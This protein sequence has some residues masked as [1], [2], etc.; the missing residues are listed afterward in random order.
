[1]LSSLATSAKFRECWA[2]ASTR[3]AE[4]W[5]NRSPKSTAAEPPQ[6]GTTAF[7]A[8][9]HGSAMVAIVV[10]AAIFF[11]IMPVRCTAIVRNFRPSSMRMVA[12]APGKRVRQQYQRQE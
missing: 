7:V 10:A 4:Q 11:M 12:T 8:L 5:A 6:E 2:A 3:I 1:M 9:L